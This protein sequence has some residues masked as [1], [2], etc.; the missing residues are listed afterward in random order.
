MDSL[1]NPLI[2]LNYR[3]P[4]YS[5][6]QQLSG[7]SHCACRTQGAFYMTV[8]T[9]AGRRYFSMCTELMLSILLF[10][11]YI[12]YSFTNPVQHFRNTSL[13][14]LW[15][16]LILVCYSHGKVSS[17]P[18][19]LHCCARWWECP[20]K[21]SW[22]NSAGFN[23]RCSSYLTPKRCI[24]VGEE[25]WVRIVLSFTGR[26]MP[27][28]LACCRIQAELGTVSW[29]FSHPSPRVGYRVLE[30]NAA[31]P[32]MPSLELQFCSTSYSSC[33]LTAVSLRARGI[34]FP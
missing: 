28:C 11:N 17:R 3:L 18:E 13:F 22:P 25:L 34:V 23:R 9:W 31:R 12:T 1:I 32:T 5:W 33:F 27:C 10:A 16:I 2:A 24:L 20:R 19:E 4:R 7:I 21:T 26:R 14:V 29:T 30:R 15:F 6:I 8:P